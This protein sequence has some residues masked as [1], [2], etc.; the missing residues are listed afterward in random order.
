MGMNKGNRAAGFRYFLTRL[1][2]L[3]LAAVLG[4]TV[5]QVPAM[6]GAN[7]QTGAHAFHLG[8]GEDRL[9]MRVTLQ[10]SETVKVDFPFSEALI[11]SPE[12]ADIVPLTN[13]SVYVLGKKIGVTRLSLLD[14]QK[15]VLGIVDIEVSYDV[16]ALR[17]TLRDDPAFRNVR[18]ST[19]NGKI[20]L[21]GRVP[22]APSVHRAAL[23]AEQIAPGG[24]TNAITVTSPQQV[25][26]EVRFVEATRDIERGFGVNWLVS[27]KN[28]KGA[29]GVETMST[30]SK[31]N[32][33]VN[34]AA[35]IASSATPFGSMIGRVL[36]GGVKADIIV[37]A[38]EE[39][40]LARRLA[41]PNLVALSGQPANFLAGGEFPFP[42]SADNGKVTTS[43][44]KFGIG[45]AFTP[46]VLNDG[47][48]SLVI[49]PEVSELDYSNG[50]RISSGNG[51]SIVVP[52]LTVRRAQTTVELREGQSFAIAGLLSNSHVSDERQLPWIGEVPVLGAL[53]RS[54]SFQKKETDLVIIVTPRLVKP[55]VPGQR[56]ATPLDRS[57]PGNDADHFLLGRQEVE[58]PAPKEYQGHIIDYQPQDEVPSDLKDAR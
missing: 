2:S 30:D 11:G 58:R 9:S 31:G 28:G 51:D 47:Q 3:A 6:A 34:L 40:G 48:I 49:E 37:K 23:L 8:Q 46:T 14:A 50:V 12:V 39:R 43:F 55:R 29:T 22:D 38:L 41:E 27:G 15:Q 56:L 36:D 10:K 35:G 32:D 20:L 1:G 26:L 18:V 5:M 17:M 45:L 13:K 21:A 24:V 16:D 57:V 52:G 54:S 42:V 25:M 53:F 4:V 19:V 44:K 7:K 33:V